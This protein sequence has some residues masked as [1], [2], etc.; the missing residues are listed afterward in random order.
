[1]RTLF[2][3]FRSFD[4]DFLIRFLPLESLKF[5][6]QSCIRYVQ[7][8]ER[9]RLTISK[10][11]YIIYAC[12]SM[13]HVHFSHVICFSLSLY[14]YFYFSLHLFLLLIFKLLRAECSCCVSYCP[15]V[16]KCIPTIYFLFVIFNCQRQTKAN[17]T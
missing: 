13:F 3:H 12:W 5:C 6:L 8:S 4:D 1:M 11:V 14:F 16:C 17:I 10:K 2:L 15:H 9:I 7:K